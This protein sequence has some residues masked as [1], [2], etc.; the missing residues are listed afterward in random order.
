MKKL[1]IAIIIIIFIIGI[2]L[3]VKKPSVQAPTMQTQD[4]IENPPILDQAIIDELMR[5]QDM[6][7]IPNN[8]VFSNN[9]VNY[10]DNGFSASSL[11]IKAG[12]NVQ[13]VNQSN[14]GMWV[15]SGP[16]T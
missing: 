13:F 3:F 8:E 1:S 9:V 5:N 10:T 15:A 12:E 6:P 4:Q 16:H 14:V 11:E 2:Y 7:N